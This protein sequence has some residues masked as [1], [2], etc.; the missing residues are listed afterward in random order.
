MHEADLTFM[1]ERSVAAGCCVGAK[2]KTSPFSPFPIVQRVFTWKTTELSEPGSYQN[3]ITHFYLS[4]GKSD[5][6]YTWAMMLMEVSATF[7]RTCTGVCCGSGIIF[8]ILV[9][10]HTASFSCALKGKLLWSPLPQNLL[11]LL[12][13]SVT[14][15]EQ[16]SCSLPFWTLYDDKL[17]ETDILLMYFS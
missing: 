17:Q 5:F 8:Y 11:L 6:P 15:C 13:H 2:A 4:S 1:E 10:N 3:C 12:G 7:S 16:I 9:I 14:C